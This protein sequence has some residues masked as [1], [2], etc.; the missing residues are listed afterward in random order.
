V[1]CSVVGAA[2]TP[3]AVQ[4][5]R[6]LDVAAEHAEG[7][8]W[9]AVSQRL[10]FVDIPAGRIFS[11]RSG[12]TPTVIHQ[13]DR[14][15]SFVHPAM[16]GDLV[17]AVREGI[18]VLGQDGTLQ[19]LAAPL[20]DQPGI[21]M[22]DGNV[23]PRGRLFAGSMA[24]DAAPGASCL[25]R[26]DPNGHLSTE[27]T[28]V[29]ISNGIDWSPDGSL[30]YYVDSATRRVDVFDYDLD[31]GRLS[32]RR[33]FAEFSEDLGLPDGLTVDAA[34][35]VWVALFGG[36]QVRRYT[37]DAVLDCV[38]SVPQ[39]QLVTSCCFGG[40]A[41]DQ[42]YISTSTENLTARQLSAQ[43]GAGQIYRAAPGYR[44]KPLATFI[45]PRP[46]GAKP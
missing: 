9:D 29:T 32:R 28:D 2:M 10:L 21:R 37:R 31:R 35:G 33:S 16:N 18:A 15:V 20:Q 40:P 14:E 1:R 11:Y 43:P 27:L 3:R 44:G 25:Y 22:N 19:S 4:A 41:L 5:S 26:L 36:G 45:A 42:L 6:I 12:S 46:A 8:T 13:L 39:A 7:I 17:V 23:D 24:Y 34:G 30:A 38:V